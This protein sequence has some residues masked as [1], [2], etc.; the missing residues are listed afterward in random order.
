MGVRG[1]AGAVRAAVAGGGDS[2]ACTV[3]ADVAPD[4]HGAGTGTG[5]LQALWPAPSATYVA[6]AKVTPMTAL[7][8]CWRC[9]ADIDMEHY[10]AVS[11]VDAVACRTSI[12][13]AASSQR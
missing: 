1:D 11:G 3:G 10:A 5:Q 12:Q 13:T 4:G 6:T 9:G 8:Q 7:T 2:V